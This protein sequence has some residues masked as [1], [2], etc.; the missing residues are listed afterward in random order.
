[1]HRSVALIPV[2]AVIAGIVWWFVDDS[3]P[4]R[5]DRPASR[6]KSAPHPVSGP[7]S[8]SDDAAGPEGRYRLEGLVPGPITLAAGRPG[9]PPRSLD[10]VDVAR[11]SRHDLILPPVC[12]VRGRVL[13]QGMVRAGATNVVL[14]P[15]RD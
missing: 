2:V 13:I 11:V 9:I 4:R 6:V 14:A 12:A 15:S 8:A 3:A 5:E 1:L 7:V 10:L